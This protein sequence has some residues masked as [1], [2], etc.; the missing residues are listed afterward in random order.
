M[1]REYLTTSLPRT[2][3][4][5]EPNP[6]ADV[7]AIMPPNTSLEVLCEG[8]EY[9]QVSVWVAERGEVTAFVESHKIRGQRMSSRPNPLE[10]I[11]EVNELGPCVC[12]AS[13]WRIVPYRGNSYGP[14]YITTG[15]LSYVYVQ[16]RV[17]MA[18][19]RVE[20][21]ISKDA[22]EKIKNM[23]QD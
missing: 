12:K 8:E 4:R 15:F 10:L 19:G 11:P 13:N 6:K 16:A 22:I 18:C 14:P 3:L 5:T 2:I 20:Q 17:C 21:Y 7:V 9:T 1:T 23:S